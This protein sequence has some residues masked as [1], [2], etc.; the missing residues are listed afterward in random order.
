[1]TTINLSG[2]KFVVQ[3][4]EI[5][6]VS[7]ATGKYQEHV[8]L[9]KASIVNKCPEAAVFVFTDAREIGAPPH[10][11]S[12]YS[13]KPYA[14]DYVRK[15]GY[16]YV[17]WCD[18]VIRLMN[19]IDTLLPNI[20]RAGVYLQADGWPVGKWANDRALAYFNVSRDEAMK[21]EAL[22]A[23]I[24]A[25]DFANPVATEF[26]SRWKKASDDGIFIGRWNND[27]K[28]ESQDERCSGHRHDQTC[29]ELISYAMN[30]PREPGLFKPNDYF[31][32]YRIGM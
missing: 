26:L 12:P 28:T 7:F 27:L 1:M 17:F 22:Y 10:A 20:A 5:A 32:S 23:C 4:R 13:F 16:R 6:F 21:I 2:G 25:F 14:V 19:T 24:M 31:K 29:A 8:P 15:L 30:I 3:R 11:T 18:I 9:F